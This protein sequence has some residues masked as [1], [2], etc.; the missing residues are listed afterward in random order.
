MAIYVTAPFLPPRDE[1]EKIL[2][3][4]WKSER[5]ANYGPLTREFEAAAKEYL[6]VPFFHFLTNGTLALQLLLRGVIGND[7]NAEIITTPFSYVATTSA[8]LWE[9]YKPVY[10]DIDSETLC[11]SPENVRS[12]ITPRTRAILAVHVF[13]IPCAVEEIELIGR[14]Y[15]IPILYD[16][17]HAFG[18]VYKGKSLLSYGNASICSFHATKPFHTGEGGCVI[19]HDEKLS[20][21]IELAKRFGHHGDNHYILGINAKPTEFQAAMG[22][23]NLSHF[24]DVVQKRK[25]AADEYTSILNHPN[26]SIVKPQGDIVHNYA[27]FPVLFQNEETLLRVKSALEHA[28]IFPRRYF[29]PALNTLP[30][31][32]GHYRCPVAKDIASRIL[33]LP[34]SHKLTTNHIQKISDIILRNI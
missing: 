1:Y 34:L 11:I 22:L 23:V 25:E 17:A 19:T 10:A 26:I 3:T 5:I 33:C 16:G 28:D 8:I 30:Y 2:K 29:F 12:L 4:V 20:S 14:E 6:N 31:V 13:G 32:P 15:N 7:R 21:W 18:V 27:Y 24:A 9:G